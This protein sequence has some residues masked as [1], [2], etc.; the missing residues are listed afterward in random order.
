MDSKP[1]NLG[2]AYLVGK[3]MESGLSRRQAV[4]VVNVILERMIRALKRGGEVEFP[5]GKL[6]RVKRHFSKLWDAVGD[7]PANRNP[8]TVEHQ[9]D[10]AGDQE[11]NGWQRLETGR[12]RR[13]RTGK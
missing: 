7:T 6:K 9:L 13:R 11:L 12:G 3:L 8:Y 1:R 4:L 10:E 2:R 5:F